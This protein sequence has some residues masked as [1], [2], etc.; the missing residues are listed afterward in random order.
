VIPYRL[1]DLY[2]RNAIGEHFG[3]VFL[4]LVLLGI[5]RVFQPETLHKKQ[6]FF[7]IA[8]SALGWAGMLLSNIPMAVTAIYTVPVYCWVRFHS[9][10]KKARLLF[11]ILGAIIG[12]MIAAIYLLPIAEFSS[13]IKLS[14]LWDIRRQEGDTGYSL[15]DF[16]NGSYRFFYAGLIATFFIGLWLLYK[17]YDDNRSRHKENIKTVFISLLVIA[18]AFQIP[19][20][21][22][23]LWGILPLL[24]LLQFTWRWNIVIVLASAVYAGL[25]FVIRERSSGKWLVVISSTLTLIIA[26]GYFVTMDGWNWKF[27]ALSGNID[28]PEYITTFATND[29]KL[30]LKMFAEHTMDPL[31]SVSGD[32]TS[33]HLLLA[34]PD[35]V[36]FSVDSLLVPTFVVFHRMYFPA[37]KLRDQYGRNIPLTADSIGRITAIL[38]TKSTQ[39]TLSLEESEAEKAGKIISFAGLSLFIF[40]IIFL[41]KP[42]AS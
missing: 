20:L 29:N 39:Y 6:I 35:D 14:H 37:W 33:F 26:T 8:I 23:L 15:I 10:K 17:F 28:A 4:P 25:N 1:L 19:L 32:Q 38:P 18:I 22:E 2:L 41:R 3:F 13:S 30:A 9:T 24:H 11:P 31:M 7:C 27:K 12:A 21:L 42:K 5:E 40:L 36:R 16:L 34:R